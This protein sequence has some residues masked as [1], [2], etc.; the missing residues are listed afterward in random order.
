[1]NRA[2]ALKFNMLSG[3][4]L[5]LIT[6]ITGLVLPRLILVVFGSSYNGM[7][8]A[9]GQYL[10]FTTVLRAGLGGVT[11][12]ALFKPLAEKDEDKISSIVSAT[13]IFMK[14]VAVM[15]GAYIAI[16]A[17]IFPFIAKSEYTWVETFTMVLICGSVVFMENC[18]AI[19]Y[20]ILL[21]ADQ[22]YYVQTLSVIVSRVLSF[23]VTFIMI[24]TGFSMH[25]VKLGAAVMALSDPL[26]LSIYVKKNYKINIKAKPDNSAIKQRWDAFAQ[27]MAIVVNG[28]VPLVLMSFFVHLKEVSV[29]TVHCMVTL[30]IEKLISSMVNGINA[31][32]GSMLAN[33]EEENL[34][35]TFGFIE[36]GLF[37]VC[38]VV[39]SVTAVMITPFIRIY[40][41]SVSDVN[42]IRPVFAFTLTM[43]SMMN[44]MRIPYQMLVEAAGH[45]RQTRNASILEVIINV[46][47]SLVMLYFYGITGVIIGSFVATVIRTFLFATYALKNILKI[48][49]MHLMKS[50][51]LYFVVFLCISWIFKSISAIEMSGY[52]EWI[53]Y[54]IFV[55]VSTV[56][57][58]GIISVIFNREQIVYL[59]KK[60]KR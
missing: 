43:V 30:N 59:K 12:A 20:K 18:F 38:A 32:F 6:L 19:K 36:W 41:N 40:T 35:K 55:T 58:V 53:K 7:I 39:F 1:M 16:F 2:K 21:Q 25:M 31:T 13:N 14:K 34:K 54:A 10:G 24:K 48:S 22:K 17:I 15:V 3:W 9:I 49:T 27:Q 56:A 23:V 37:A 50:Y 8:G 47:V 44:C 26:I 46:A 28:N 45:F 11:R 52:I 4:L 57:I 29:Y 42:Y 51:V 5:E 33:N 60:I